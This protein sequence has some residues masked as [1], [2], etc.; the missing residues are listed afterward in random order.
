MSD[1]VKWIKIQDENKASVT[2]PDNFMSP[3]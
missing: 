3:L 2:G 1:R